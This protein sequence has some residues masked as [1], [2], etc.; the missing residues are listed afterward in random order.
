MSLIS[1]LVCHFPGSI[2]FQSDEWETVVCAAHRLQNAIKHG[3]SASETVQKLLALARK[4]VG[5][6]RHSA[7]AT[8]A[9]IEKQK[10]MTPSEQPKKLIQAS[11]FSSLHLQTATTVCY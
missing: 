11:A 2:L 9:L 10:I 4:V 6:F 5:H 1:F 3:L 8:N 7:L